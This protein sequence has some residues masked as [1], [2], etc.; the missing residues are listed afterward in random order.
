M[1]QHQELLKN[2]Y[3]NIELVCVPTTVATS[4]IMQLTLPTV[5]NPCNPGGVS[6]DLIAP[7]PRNTHYIS[8][9]V[10]DVMPG[11]TLGC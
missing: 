6:S 9:T 1:A 2:R 3:N 10:G 7:S 4:S 8:S 5:F 11:M